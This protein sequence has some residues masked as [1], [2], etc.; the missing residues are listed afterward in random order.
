[1][2]VEQAHPAPAS[3]AAGRTWRYARL[4]LQAGTLGAGRVVTGHTGS[5]RA[6][7]LL[8]NLARGCGPRGL[9]SLRRRR[10]L[11]DGVDLVRPL[12]DVSRADTAAYCRDRQ[13]PLWLDPSNADPRYG[14][15]RIRREVLPVLEALHPGAWERLSGLGERLES[16]QDLTAELMPLALET[17]RAPAAP[18]PAG[19]SE[20]EPALQRQALSALSGPT[21]EA[22]LDHW[23]ERN[24][25]IRLGARNLETLR[26]R[27]LP[28]RGPGS[29][30]LPG[31]RSL[32]WDRVTLRLLP[33]LSQQPDFPDVSDS[34][35]ATSPPSR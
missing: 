7:T 24:V 27:L 23:L 32:I 9:S 20:L 26:C 3:E 30:R 16:S 21:Q 35:S 19:A 13:L 31:G 12:L 10:R 18:A 15:N 34:G 22:L 33:P 1:M 14:R 4:L 2:L 5:D 28:G 11:G 8:L 17:L 25:G 29:L 6:E